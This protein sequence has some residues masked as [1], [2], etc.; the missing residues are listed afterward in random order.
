M[1]VHCTY[2]FHIKLVY[3]CNYIKK[4]SLNIVSIEHR[5]AYK[6]LPHSFKYTLAMFNSRSNLQAHSTMK[7]SLVI[8]KH[9]YISNKAVFLIIHGQKQDYKKTK[10]KWCMTKSN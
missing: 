10:Q 9:L 4:K 7:I 8:Y 3:I 6:C 1:N 5:Q 2:S